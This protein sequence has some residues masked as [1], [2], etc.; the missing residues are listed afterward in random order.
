MIYT[1]MTNKA[2]RI[3]YKAHH[4]QLDYNGIPYIFHPIHLAEQMDDEISC[5]AAL[6]HDVVEDTDVTMEDLAR[7]F[8]AQVIDVLKLLTHDDDVPYFDYVRE[9]K[10]HPVAKKV[11]LAD[12]AH[13]S[14]QTRCVGSDLTE[15]RLA[16]WKDKYAKATKILM[17][18]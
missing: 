11:K 8:P 15:E 10:K 5:C 12:L 2:M 14:D 17:E 13:N 18:D 16:Y 6:L 7:E 4:V 9:I 3:A 1:T